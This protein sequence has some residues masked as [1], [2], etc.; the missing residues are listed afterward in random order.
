MKRIN[1]YLILGIVI[2]LFFSVMIMFPRLF[3]DKSP[4]EIV[5]VES[6]KTEEGD[7]SFRAPA[8]EPSERFLWGT[9]DS[10]RDIFSFIIYGARL[11]LIIGLSVAFLRFLFGLIIG[12]RAAL[13]NSFSTLF[14]DQFN[15]VFNAIPPLIICLIILSIDYLS[16]LP[17][18]YS[19]IVFITVMTLVEWARVATFIRDRAEEI[20][21]KDFIKSERIIGKSD[22]AIVFENLLPHMFSELII[23]FFMEI[24][25]VL[26]LMM[27]LGIFGIFIGNLKIVAD[28]AAGVIVGK[29]TS[30]EPEWAAMLGSSKNYIRVAPWIVLACSSMFFLAVLGFNFMGEG[31]RMLYQEGNRLFKNKKQFISTI[32]VIVLLFIAAFGITYQPA[33][34][35]TM[36]KETFKDLPQKALVG[37]ESTNKIAEEISERFE[38]L[39]LIQTKDKYVFPYEIPSYNYVISKQVMVEYNSIIKE[40]KEVGIL[41]FGSYNVDGEVV[42]LRETDI[43]GKDYE[44]ESFRNHVA[45][46]F[47]LLEGDFFDEEGKVFFSQRLIDETDAL[48]V[49]IAVE[50]INEKNMGIVSLTKPIITVGKSDADTLINK[51]IS[52]DIETANYGGYGNNIVGQIEC[53]NST[54][55]TK[56]VIIGFEYNYINDEIGREQLNTAFDFIESIVANQDRLKRNVVIVFWDG[57]YDKN[58]S[59]LNSYYNEYYYTIK[60]SLV[61]ID[62]TG[63]YKEE[64]IQDKITYNSD[65]ITLTKPDSYSIAT[66][67]V[68]ELGQSSYEEITLKENYSVF[69]HKRGIQT[70]YFGTNGNVRNDKLIK[71][72]SEA[73]VE[74]LVR[75][76]Y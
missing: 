12:I 9:D 31:L 65:Y 11:T 10:G 63:L 7:Y 2:V 15:N 3:T 74:S 29:M 62:M 59:G 48:G 55:N 14:I 52:I 21:E 73:I 60:H 20:L 46:A 49:I 43:I 34:A 47:V 33:V 66:F 44:T 45:G 40:I 41:S 51:N 56:G 26:T 69:Y 53:P 13:G 42:D 28:T 76:M 1:I 30:Y 70:L 38:I 8:Y 67:L 50:N 35:L 71:D 4:Y 32:I 37:M 61:Y 17:K 22:T 39:G 6:Y 16:A 68:D 23:L 75:I 72:L 64:G 58:L 5:G 18:T 19:I 24:S 54:K 57:A 36:K 25:R 27:Q